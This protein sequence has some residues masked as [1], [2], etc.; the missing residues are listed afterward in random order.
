MGKGVKHS[1][2]DLGFE[3]SVNAFYIVLVDFTTNFTT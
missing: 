3:A 2:P 1:K